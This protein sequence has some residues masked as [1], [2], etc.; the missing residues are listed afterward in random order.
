MGRVS[1]LMTL[2]IVVLGGCST[3][4]SNIQNDY[5]IP[6]GS[7]KGL[8]VMSLT[9]S[10]ECGF[11]HFV[12]MRA[13]GKR[14]TMLV[15]FEDKPE[16]TYDPREC[17]LPQEHFTGRLAVLELPVGDYEIDGYFSL[18]VRDKYYP[19][20]TPAL[21]VSIQA[22]KVSYIGNIHL[23]VGDTIY[24]RV[25]SEKTDRDMDLLLKRYPRVDQRLVQESPPLQQTAKRWRMAP[26]DYD[27][28]GRK[29]VRSRLPVPKGDADASML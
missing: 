12:R 3:I 26:G 15:P 17:P 10:G 24:T 4:P 28:D 6:A 19:D 8:L 2:L 22:G 5:M 13:A 29:P 21:N 1:V 27:S 18:T 25:T 9:Y 7:E 16:W 23:H 20:E 11:S 14:T